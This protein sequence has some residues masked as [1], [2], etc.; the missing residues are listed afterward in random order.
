ME[1]N[2]PKKS[3]YVVLM[4][5]TLF[6]GYQWLMS[7]ISK[8]FS[9]S[10]VSGFHDKI[11]SSVS[12]AFGFYVPVLKGIVLPNATF[13][14]YFIE[15]S[16]LFIGAVFIILFFTIFGRVQSWLLILGMIASIWSA[17]ISINIFLYSGASFFANPAKPFK[18]SIS[19]DLIFACIEIS[20]FVYFYRLNHATAAVTEKSNRK[21]NSFNHVTE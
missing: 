21:N 5:V 10:F 1:Y 16:E 3:S 17:F 14:G 11:A 13:F 6:I 20:L 19:M 4:F 7:G 2:Q 18:P 8:L 9:Q 15:Y 12:K